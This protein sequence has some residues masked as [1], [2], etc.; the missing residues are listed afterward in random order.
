MSSRVIDILL[1]IYCLK[2]HSGLIEYVYCS[3]AAVNY[4][5]VF[6]LFEAAD[7]YSLPGLKRL[8][9]DYLKKNANIENSID[10]VNFAEKYEADGLRD[11]VLRYIAKNFEKVFD[12]ERPVQLKASTLLEIY[13]KK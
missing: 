8:C 5:I 2:R 13:R 6:E 7:K 12:K 4:D 9:E 11:A 3:T 10:I 1:K